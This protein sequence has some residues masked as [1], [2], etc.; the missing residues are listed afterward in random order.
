MN[1]F[2]LRSWWMLALRGGLAIVFGVLALMWPGLT[3]MALVAAFAAYA[4]L[5][6]VVAITAAIRHRRS[7]EEWW[8]VLALGVA[9]VVAGALSV[10]RPEVTALA[11]VFFMAAYAILIGTLDIAVAIRLHRDLP[12]KWLLGLAGAVSIAFGIM[13]FLFPDA[14]TLAMIWLISVYALASGAMLLTLGFRARRW[15]ELGTERR[16]RS[17]RREDNGRGLRGG[18]SQL[19]A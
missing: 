14:G 18:V 8:L 9:G 3:L 15:V 4:F 12:D 6:G 13:V 16:L 17:R 1:Q 19:H 10:L 11:L 7:D 5:S 2:L